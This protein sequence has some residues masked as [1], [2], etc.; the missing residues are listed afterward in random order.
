LRAWRY[1][2][3]PAVFVVASLAVVV[4]SAGIPLYWLTPGTEERGE[5]IRIFFAECLSLN[6]TRRETHH[7]PK[8]FSHL[9]QRG[10]GRRRSPADAA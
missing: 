10:T 3:A 8:I 1:P 7:G 2:V 4:I 6:D 5:L 9:E